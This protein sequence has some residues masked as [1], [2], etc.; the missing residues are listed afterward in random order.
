MGCIVPQ[1]A[2]CACLPVSILPHCS[3]AVNTFAAACQ[4]T[5]KYCLCS[6]SP[7]LQAAENLYFIPPTNKGF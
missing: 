1:A 6:L 7:H 2:A 3:E 5:V 4:A